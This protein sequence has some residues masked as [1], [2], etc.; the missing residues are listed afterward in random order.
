MK[1]N[2]LLIFNAKANMSICVKLLN[3]NINMKK[4]KIKMIFVW[5]YFQHI[6]HLAV[7]VNLV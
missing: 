6:W 5:N 3:I 2:H 4:I 1:T 7:N